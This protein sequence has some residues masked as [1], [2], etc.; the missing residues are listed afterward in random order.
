MFRSFTLVVATA[1]LAGAIFVAAAGTRP[2]E[3][4]VEP[5]RDQAA[6]MKPLARLP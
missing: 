1:S 6:A 4:Y 5:G 3:L 2:R